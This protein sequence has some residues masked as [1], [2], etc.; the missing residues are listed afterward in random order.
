MNGHAY[1]DRPITKPQWRALAACLLMAAL[2]VVAVLAVIAPT[3]NAAQD[4]PLRHTFT[5]EQIGFADTWLTNACGFEVNVVVGGTFEEKLELGNDRNP[6]AHETSK[7]DGDITWIAEASGKTYSDEIHNTS[8]IDYPDGVGEYGL[9]AHVTV[10][11]SHAGTF[12]VGGGPPGHGK[13]EYEAGFLL[14]GLPDDFPF[15]FATSEG[16]WTGKSF[17]RATEK[18]CSALS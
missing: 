14:G 8:K 11:G 13:F 6:A 16:T 17:E 1:P 2:A 10:T 4:R 9:P 18:I 15:V 7:F 12:P 3:A 5:L